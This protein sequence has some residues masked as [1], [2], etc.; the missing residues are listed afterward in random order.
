MPARFLFFGGSGHNGSIPGQ[1]GTPQAKG[2]S[3]ARQLVRLVPAEPAAHATPTY[4][5]DAI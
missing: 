4:G 5:R 1:S 3:E 2:N